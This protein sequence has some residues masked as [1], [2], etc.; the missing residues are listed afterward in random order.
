MKSISFDAYLRI[1]IYIDN[2]Q[3]ISEDSIM[4]RENTGGENGIG[5][6]IIVQA[7]A[8]SG[9]IYTIG[10]NLLLEKA[11][12]VILFISATTTFRNDKYMDIC[13]KYIDDAVKTEYKDLLGK[14]IKDYQTLFNRIEL[15]T[16]D[17]D[18]DGELDKLPTDERLNKLKAG[19]DDLGLI[20]LY[21]QF[22]WYLMISSSR[23]RTLLAN[24]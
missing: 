9:K 1:G 12:D 13:R 5:F 4:M 3:R 7:V 15:D 24:L 11:D 8:K 17:S 21:F 20:C 10:E 2:L 22:G 16:K 18:D 19:A 6:Y 14:H 23:L